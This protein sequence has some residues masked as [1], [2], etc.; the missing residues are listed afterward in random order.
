MDNRPI[1]VFDSGLGGLTAVK[2]LKRVLPNE[3]I[4]YFGDTG[5]VPYGTKSAETIVKYAKQ[6]MNFLLSNNVKCVVAA[7]GT[8][9][10]TAAHVGNQLPVPYIDVITPTAKA[11]AE[12]TKNGRIGIL[13][14]SATIKSGSFVKKLTAINPDLQLFS[15]PC[16]LFVSLVESGFVALGDEVTS[17]AA[18]RYLTRI[19]A[20]NVDTVILGCT[21]FP[22]IKWAIGDAV[23]EKVKLIDSGKETARYLANLLKEKDMLCEETHKADYHYWVSDST[24]GFKNVAELFLGGYVD[25]EIGRI[26]IEKY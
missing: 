5:R 8:V 14:T 19:N 9:S 17:L 25:G 20:E 26:D 22:I 12:Y 11:A 7:C 21:H 16:P 3:S 13:G 24:E 2:E 4:V 23:G 15:E 1:G 18:R 10:S 6:D